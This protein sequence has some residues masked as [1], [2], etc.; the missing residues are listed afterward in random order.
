MNAKSAMHGLK[1]ALLATT[2]L[3]GA[4]AYAQLTTATVR[5]N[6]TNGQAP[7]PGATVTAVNVD[8]GFTARGTVGQSGAYVLT[9]VR[10]GTYDIS[11]AGAGGGTVSR[12][13][14]ISVGQTATIDVDVAA[15][16]TTI[17][18]VVATADGTAPSD[19]DGQVITVTGNRLIET[20]TSEIAT[21]VSN[22]QIENLPQNNRNFLNF[23]A[24][25]PGI[26]VNQTE[27]RQTFAGGGVGTGRDGDSFGG[28]QVNVFID[29]VSLKSNVNQ[30][31]VVGQD[32]SR[33]NPFSQLAVQEFRVLTSNF[34][35]EFE[36]A[37]TSIITAVTRSGTNKFRGEAFGTY[38]DK[39]LVERNFF[40]K[41]RDEAKPDLKRYQYGAALGGP[42]IKDRLFFF[43]NYEANIQDRTN[44]VVPGTPPTGVTLPINPNDFAGSFTSPFREHLGFG[45]LTWQINDAQVLELSGSLRIETDLRDFG[46][47]AAR[48][49]GSSVNNDVY[50]AKLRHDW[51]GEGFLNEFTADYLKSDLKFGA[52]G[53]AGF[54][55]SF[56][57]VIQIG[58][59]A[60]FQEVGQES[61]T[62]RNNFSL[63]DVEFHGRHLIKIGGKLS[64]QDYLV[65]GS[66]PNANPQ[67][68][69]LRD[70][71]RGLD[72]D[73]PA[74]V[75]FGG[76]DPEVRASTTQIGLFVQDDWEVNEHLLL[77]LG[78]R[79]DY[80]SNA[81]NNSFVTSTR[82]AEALRRLGQDPRI[83]DFFDVED[84]ISTG[85]REAELDNFA[86]RIGLSYDL[87]ADQRT[88]F[89][90]GY[91][92]YYDRALFRSAAE[93]TLFSQF[94]SGE[95]LFSRN[96]QPRDGRATIQFRPEYLT[97]DGF[98]ALLAS[99][100]AD[101]TSP[102]TS[103]L[104]IIPNNLKTP[105]TDQF[106]LGIRQRLGPIRTS[107]TLNHT[108]GK[109][110]I[111]YAPLNRTEATNADGFLDFI[112]LINGFSNAV[113]AFNTRATKYNAVFVQI[114][115]PYTRA[116]GYGFGIAYTYADSKERGFAFNFDFPN[117]ED[118]P[119]V[120]N[121]G[122][123]KHRIV[124]NGIVDLP[125]D[126]RLSGLVTYGSG[127][128]YFV[129]DASRGFG[130][131]DIRFPG[132]VGDLPHFLQVDVRLQK[133]FKVFGDREISLSAEVFNL[134]NRANF[135]GAEG[136][137]PRLPEVNAGFGNPNSL[138]G[139]P[140]SFQFG[141][142]VR[143]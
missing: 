65:G 136:F 78:L 73:I 51:S 101:P 124:A 128:P 28:P 77:N 99:L 3:V 104:R 63:T 137:I 38:Q 142:A 39:G 21:N 60:D 86:P 2:L 80:D 83:G 111:G 15:N 131:R 23:A 67:F 42:I 29:G 68:E 75:R 4:P 6:V 138:A 11:Y 33:G 113:A 76:G 54:G 72:F 79:W 132:N 27:F 115:K 62:F 125:L 85:D 57:G 123:E 108:R 82:A 52:L 5:G 116:S 92:R 126:F 37:G 9:G 55:R 25:A 36:D 81:K 90:A 56:Q 71:P 120:P 140:R 7:A 95:L 102:G 74:L 26:S 31:G 129:I 66:G 88:V 69:F 35:A 61:F 93:E 17:D 20:R 48:E 98:A 16:T 44:V 49:R 106:S 141:A 91:G 30:G 8:T 40:Q 14:T 112:P 64:F 135:G 119:F 133:I 117:I 109:N 45:K 107:V 43:A 53:E 110:Q 94:R 58:G 139:P 12:R 34:K 50:T 32:V 97:Q 70:A 118:R 1:V 10:P 47:Q 100:A 18:D 127:V 96:G 59:R 130:A 13:V 122:D 24:L 105:Y 22:E 89:F 87:N 41:E 121:A 114:E 143:F 19:S 46:G 134:F 84:Y 103:E